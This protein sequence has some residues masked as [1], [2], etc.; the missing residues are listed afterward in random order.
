MEENPPTAITAESEHDR[1]DVVRQALKKAVEKSAVTLPEGDNTK[2]NVVILAEDLVVYR[3]SNFRFPGKTLTVFARRII[4]APRPGGTLGSEAKDHQVVFDCTGNMG[5]DRYSDRAKTS[6]GKAADGNAGKRTKDASFFTSAEHEGAQSGG[7]G[8]NGAQGLAGGNGGN[9]YFCAQVLSLC[10]PDT[11]AAVKLIARGG[12]GTQGQ[13]GGDGGN[14]GRGMPYDAPFV[15]P[16]NWVFNGANGGSGGNGGAGGNGGSGGDVYVRVTSAVPSP[17]RFDVF[18]VQIDNAGGQNGPSGQGGRAEEGGWGTTAKE[19]DFL[20]PTVTVRGSNGSD[21]NSGSSST[22]NPFTPPTGKQLAFSLPE[23]GAFALAVNPAFA[24]MLTQRLVFEYDV[25]F[26]SLFD[27]LPKTY[28]TVERRRFEKSLAWAQ[29]IY[30]AIGAF[31][32][33]DTLLNGPEAA[34]LPSH[35]DYEAQE[36]ALRE[37]FGGTAWKDDKTQKAS[38]T[39]FALA[40]EKLLSLGGSVVPPVPATDSFGHTFNFVPD[41]SFS[42]NRL[43]KA[44]ADLEVAEARR[45]ALSQA[46]ASSNVKAAEVSSRIQGFSDHIAGIQ[47]ERKEVSDA[48]ALAQTKINELQGKVQAA[49]KDCVAKLNRFDTK[50]KLAD[51]SC[52]NIEKV[53][54]AAASCMMFTPHARGVALAGNFLSVGTAGMDLFNTVSTNSGGAVK[55]D[56]LQGQFKTIEANHSGKELTKQ[57][58]EFTSGSNDKLMKRVMME[59]ARFEKLCDEHFPGDASADERAAFDSVVAQARALNEALVDN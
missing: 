20:G 25:L 4:I 18:G 36:K 16:P 2:A 21:G 41:I 28:K 56:A 15:H 29:E 12:N 46:A 31:G 3:G 52:D 47:T 35:K 43:V 38:R 37:K 6:K 57:I 10:R 23:F 14:G 48:V 5:E 22:G 39:I 1:T 11:A 55:K 45:A 17:S 34:R 54:G 7:N 58:G 42:I 53:L 27:I 50:E 33:S 9:I 44:A 49:I 13:R 51:F 32:S 24:H 19:S 59:Q 40:F 26:S 8:E 30:D